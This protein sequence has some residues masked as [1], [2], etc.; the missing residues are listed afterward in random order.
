V[1]YAQALR[2]GAAYSAADLARDF[3]AVIDRLQPTWVLAP[4]PLDEHADHRATGT[5]AVRAM[6]QLGEP[7][8]VRFWIVHGGIAWP[9]PR[10]LA[11]DEAL[12]PPARASALPW[13]DF[14]LLPAERTRKEAAVRVYATQMRVMSSFMLAFVKRNEIYSA[15]GLPAPPV[16]APA[17]QKTPQK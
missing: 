14:A 6:A 10:G 15:A 8:R 17:A 13:Q 1:P 12:V 16:S 5:L 3:G 11:P 4:T 7:E 9:W 2:P